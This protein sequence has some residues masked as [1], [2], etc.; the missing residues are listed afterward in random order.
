[1]LTTQDDPKQEPEKKEEP[2]KSPAK[3]AEKKAEAKPESAGVSI[4][5][6][7]TA[8]KY[9]AARVSTP[10]ELADLQRSFPNIFK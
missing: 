6:L 10:T 3:P 8:F 5:E 1:V 4:P 9:L 2:K 7:V